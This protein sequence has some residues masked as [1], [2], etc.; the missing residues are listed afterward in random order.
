MGDRSSTGIRISS[1]DLSFFD[2]LGDLLEVQSLNFA[3]L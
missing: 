3:K 2:F 1:L